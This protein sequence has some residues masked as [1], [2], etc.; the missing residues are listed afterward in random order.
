MTPTTR[1]KPTPPD[2]VKQWREAWPKALNV[3]SRFTQLREPLWCFTPR[4]NQNAGLQN[5]F[6]MIRLT[7]HT[8]VIDVAKILAEN[9]EDMGFEILAH[10]IGHHIYCP[11][12]LAD[13]ARMLI[14]V[15]RALF[16]RE[17]LAGMIGNLYSDLLINNR[18]QRHD[19][20]R[21]AEVYRRLGN[22]SPDKLWNIY[23]RIY[24]ILWSLPRLTLTAISV[25]AE[26]ERDAQL[27]ARLIRV[28][29]RDWL[30]GAGR[31]A[32]ICY[33]Y[34]MEDQ[35]QGVS[36]AIGGFFDTLA[37]A[38]GGSCEDIP[39]GL[40]ERD[41][42]EESSAVHP[43][44]DDELSGINHDEEEKGDA[45]ADGASPVADSLP[46]PPG[47]GQGQYRQPYELGEI[48]NGLGIKFNLPDLAWKY[49]RD[50]AA[51]HLVP[52]PVRRQPE[53][54][55]PLPEGLDPWDVGSPLEELDILESTLVCPR[56]IPGVTT[57]T[58][59]YGTSPGNMPK[60]E[61]VDLDLYVD[62][63]GSMPNPQVN[64]SYLAL[65]GAIIVLSALR[66]GSKIQATLWSGTNEFITTNGFIRDERNIFRTITGFIGRCTAFPIHMLRDTFQS[67][68]GTDRPVHIL[69]IS[70]DGVDTLFNKDEKGNSG[71]DISAMALK[72]SRAGGTMVLNLYLPPEKNPTFT[73]AIGQ[74]WSIHPVRNWDQLVQFAQAFSKLHFGDPDEK[75]R[76]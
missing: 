39:D 1:S 6:A 35:G 53:S 21:I 17:H 24:E 16:Q 36:Q 33:P 32:A 26:M 12:D 29:A 30:P 59:Q 72:N 76:S 65:A 3:W 54:Q 56:I 51:P 19:G 42:D 50:L 31:F 38:H 46:P 61:P 25:E 14:R 5:S 73:R 47:A 28:F 55:E 45:E 9:L 52:F 34:L 18:L 37:P 64:L 15:R 49:Y 70:D 44:L 23:L 69:I 27:G 62:S 13:H 7:D 11:A 8:V 43:A 22:K 63:S 4:D 75:R 58:R 71:W 68:T 41:P 2:V 57:V 40:L 48:L 66:A 20:L 74:G 10:E 67:R 60:S